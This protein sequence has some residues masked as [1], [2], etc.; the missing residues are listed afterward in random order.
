MSCVARAVRVGPDEPHVCPSCEL[1]FIQ[2]LDG[3]RA[4]EVHW[5]VSLWCPN[6]E[7]VGDRVLSDRLIDRLDEQLDEGIE[8]VELALAHVT[9]SN[10]REY[11]EQFTTALAQNSVLPEDF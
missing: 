8:E 4:G 6:C 11:A 5:L 10:M 2:P 3:E 7:W 1:P 9:R